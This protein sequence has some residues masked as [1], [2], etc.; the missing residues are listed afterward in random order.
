MEKKEVETQPTSAAS[1]CFFQGCSV[2]SS[3]HFYTK[4]DQLPGSRPN[5]WSEQLM[6][7]SP[8]WAVD[9]CMYSR[10]TM[11]LLAASL[12]VAV[13]AWSI[14]LGGSPCLSRLCSCAILFSFW[15]DRLN[16][17]W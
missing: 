9:L 13:Y 17:A 7:V 1:N 4:S 11:G 16:S 6:F 8:S 14:S 3:T 10:G 2:F 5:L 15:D 12:I